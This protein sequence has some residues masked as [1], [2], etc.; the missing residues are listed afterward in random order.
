[1]STQ[2]T[3]ETPTPKEPKPGNPAPPGQTGAVP[4]GHQDE[5][6]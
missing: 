2:V 1:M 3:P 6:D 4:P 5:G